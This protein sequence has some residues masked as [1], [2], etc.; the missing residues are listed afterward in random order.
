MPEESREDR[1]HHRYQLNLPVNVRW[2]A[3]EQNGEVSAV[4]RDISEGGVFLYMNSAIPG[5]AEL[6]FN[7]VL[8]PEVSAAENQRVHFTG[9]VLRMAEA[10]AGKIGVAALIERYEP[11]QE[12]ASAASI[13]EAKPEAQPEAEEEKGWKGW[14]AAFLQLVQ[15]VWK[16]AT[17]RIRFAGLIPQLAIVIVAVILVLM[18]LTYT[19][20]SGR[21]PLEQQ[22]SAGNPEVR[23]WVRQRTGRYHCP[24]SPMYGARE[25]GRFMTQREAQSNYHRPSG[26]KPCN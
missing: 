4:V 19:K 7:L 12:A 5:E 3:G 14:L 23:V 21:D 13:P 2:V 18:A 10:S 15:L 25:E 1:K 26:G 6:D 8:S 22:L 11:A 20:E 24:G 9:R 16:R 17:G